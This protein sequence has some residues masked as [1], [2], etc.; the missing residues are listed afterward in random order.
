MS[1]PAVAAWLAP[2][3][4]PAAVLVAK[5]TLLLLLAALVAAA[6]RHASASAR[7]LVWSLALLALV[8]LLVLEPLLPAWRVPVGRALAPVGLTLAPP[9][10]PREPAATTRSSLPTAVAPTPAAHT[11]A[12]SLRLHWP[13]WLLAAW[14]A[15][16]AA[17]AAWLVAGQVSLTRLTRRARPVHDERWLRGVHALADRLGLRR[18]VRLLCSDAAVMPATCGLLRPIVILPA[19]ADGWSEEHRASVLCHELAHVKRLD[20]LTQLVAQAVCALFWF[21]PGVWYA[22]R[23]LTAER[24][25]AC[26]DLVLQAGTRPSDYASHLIEVARALRPARLS[27]PA[28]VCMARPSQLEG[29]L[30][31]VLDPARRRATPARRVRCAAALAALGLVVPLAALHPSGASPESSPAAPTL[32]LAPVV[33]RAVAPAGGTPATIWAHDAVRDAPELRALMAGDGCAAAA[34]HAVAVPVAGARVVRID[35][36]AGQLWVRGS[37]GSVVRVR[38]VACARAVRDLDRARLTADHDGDAIEVDAEVARHERGVRLHVVVEVPPGMAVDVEE[39]RGDVQ[40]RDVA[41]LRVDDAAGDLRVERVR[42]DVRVDDAGGAVD[43]RGVARSVRVTG[44]GR[45]D[46]H[47]RDVGGDLAVER[48][49]RGRIDWAGVRGQVRVPPPSTASTAPTAPVP[50]AGRER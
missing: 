4:P 10:A 5:A 48:A 11:L 46:I 45:G 8:A 13:A 31:A 40:V 18:P 12:A 14:L 27:A 38:G 6:L 21:H 1:A 24:E 43:I 25:R 26:D 41:R 3:L 50:P 22:V 2:W 30:L 17:I 35:V 15:G 32:A 19:S 7:H 47:V 37:A 20:C 49:V 28:A 9:A 16:A 23:R 44:R 34:E 29:R 39:A 42:G 36:D 33:S